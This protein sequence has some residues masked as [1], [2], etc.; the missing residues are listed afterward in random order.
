MDKGRQFMKDR[1]IVQVKK[2]Q[3]EQS[4]KTATTWRRPTLQRL[5]LSLDTA[6]TFG[7]GGDMAGRTST[8]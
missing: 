7:S 6:L 2:E 1:K 8:P 5:H 4:P 3:L